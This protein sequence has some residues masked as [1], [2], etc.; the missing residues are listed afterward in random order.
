FGSAT[1]LSLQPKRGSDARLERVEVLAQSTLALEFADGNATVDG[2]PHQ[3]EIIGDSE[4][5][6]ATKCLADVRRAN[7]AAQRLLIAINHD[8]RVDIAEVLGL[9]KHQLALRP[10]QS[11]DGELRD[12]EDQIRLSNER[13]RPV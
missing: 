5:H 13:E 3:R 10:A 2:C 11:S 7:H 4:R 9:E 8:P 6:I 1:Y 12:E